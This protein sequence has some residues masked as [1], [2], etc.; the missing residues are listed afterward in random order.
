MENKHTLLF[1]Q[2]RKLRFK[3]KVLSLSKFA[4]AFLVMSKVCFISLT[5]NNK[6]YC[7]CGYV[8]RLLSQIGLTPFQYLFSLNFL[9][10]NLVG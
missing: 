8:G 3:R 1:T 10:L 2:D 9:K 7:V 6:I 4:T 5:L